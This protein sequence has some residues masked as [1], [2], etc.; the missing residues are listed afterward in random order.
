MYTCGEAL[1]APVNEQMLHKYI[2]T[3]MYTCGEAL[4]TVNA[5]VNQHELPT[6]MYTHIVL[7]YI[8]IYTYQA[9]A[10]RVAL[11]PPALV[12]LWRAGRLQLEEGA[13]QVR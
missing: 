12:R 8:Y 9:C 13:Q 7:I 5:P 6:Y 11:L 3:H 4:D 1:D 2:C 10:E